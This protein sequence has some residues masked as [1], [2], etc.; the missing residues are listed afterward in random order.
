MTINMLFYNCSK[1]TNK[2]FTDKEKKHESNFI[3]K[4]LTK[5]AI[6]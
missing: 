4:T 1:G 6:S 3:I 5:N 2:I